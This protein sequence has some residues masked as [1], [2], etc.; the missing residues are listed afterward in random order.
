ML[1]SHAAR[2]SSSTTRPKNTTKGELCAAL[3]RDGWVCD[4]GGGSAVIYRK[5]GPPTLRVSIHFHRATDTM[6]AKLLT[7]LLQDTCWSEADL[8]RLKLIK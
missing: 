2:P 5:P 7:G 8:R 6:G 3:E 4:M 1:S